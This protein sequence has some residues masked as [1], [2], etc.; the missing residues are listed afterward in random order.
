[1][2]KKWRAHI[3]LKNGAVIDVIYEYSDENFA[4]PWTVFKRGGEIVASVLRNEIVAAVYETLQ[5]ED[6]NG[7]DAG[8][9]D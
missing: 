8:S 6:D 3:Y 9:D 7:E 2:E 1:M 5:E 4:S